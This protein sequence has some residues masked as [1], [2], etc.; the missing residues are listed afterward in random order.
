M[1]RREDRSAWAR[2]AFAAA[3]GVVAAAVPALAG[4]P[5]I[6]PLVGWD[7][8][9]VAYVA[10]TWAIIWPM[11]ADATAHHAER[12][13]PDRAAA[14]L[15]LVA[16][17]VISLAAVGL[18][19]V[20]AGD[21]EGADRGMLIT[22]CVG[23]VVLA[24]TVVHTVFTLRYARL[25]H[26]GPDG[27]IDFNQDEPPSYSDFAYLAFTL[28]MTYQVSD[29]DLSSATLRRTALRH[30]LLSYVFGTVIIATTIN[31]VAGLIS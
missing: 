4:N 2:V 1:G 9:A 7:V 22:L 10:R 26:E 21:A 15:L 8:A 17:S 12:E 30:A 27:G 24:W 3:L 5:R 25:Y 14:D 28:G 20:T 11:D 23:S 6:A 16:A 31:L 18:V 13:D 29:T 19:L